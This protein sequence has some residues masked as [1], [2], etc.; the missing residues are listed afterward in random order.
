[1]VLVL[2]VIVA[3]AAI[4]LPALQGPM[5]DQRLRKAGDIVL[6]QWAKARL[7]AMKTG[8]MQVFRF[9]QGTDRY[10]VQS[11]F[12][13]VDPLEAPA[14]Q[15]EQI[16]VT[17]NAAQ[18]QR[19]NVLGVP[20]LVLP[21]GVT[22]F[23]SETEMD[24]RMMQSGTDMQIADT[25]QVGSQPIVFYPDGST[26][27]ARLVLTNERFFVELKLRGLTGLAKASELLTIEELSQ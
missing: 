20:G 22:F 27:E 16:P 25:G 12:D 13:S 4:V 23:M 21:S 1:M 3:A 11:W 8:K 24:S 19:D 17:V 10:E 5:S 7:T 26:T 6:A 14:D 18:L 2:A 9:E 15:G